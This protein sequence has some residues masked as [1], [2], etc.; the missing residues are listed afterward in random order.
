MIGRGRPSFAAIATT[1]ATAP[2][3]AQCLGGPLATAGEL[4]PSPLVAERFSHA[5]F[6]AIRR[7]KVAWRPSAATAATCAAIAC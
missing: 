4:H 1:A 2:R 5:P 6:A 3:P 7:P